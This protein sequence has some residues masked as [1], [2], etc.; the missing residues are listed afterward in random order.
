MT[1]T[2]LDTQ[3]LETA[4]G[5]LRNRISVIPINPDTKRPYGR[6]LPDELDERGQ[7]VINPQTKRPK[8]TWKPYQE[9]YA[10]EDE[11]RT[12]HA[13]GAQFAAV[14]GEISGGL[15]CIDHDDVGGRLLFEEWRA[16]VDDLADGLTTQQTGGGGYQVAYRYPVPPATTRDGNQKLAWLADDTQDTGR[17]VAIETRGEGGYFVIAPSLHPSG[18][19]YELLCGSWD[20]I[21]TISA[22]HR[23]SLLDAARRLDEMPHTRQELERAREQAAKPKATT[24]IANVNGDASVIVAYNAKTAIA[25]ELRQHGYQ[26]A[27]HGRLIRP[28]AA[29]DSQPGVVLGSGEH[30]NMSFHHSSND[31]LN[32]GYWHAPFDVRC[33]YDFNSDVKAAV[34]ALAAE[35]GMDHLSNIP[36]PPRDTEGWAICPNCGNRL[37][38]AKN[39]NGW[40]C[41]KDGGELC[42]WWKGE[43][44]TAPETTTPV[45]AD[46]GRLTIDISTIDL[47]TIMPQ[48]WHAIIASN[49]PPTLFRRAGEL[50]RLETTESGAMVV[51]TIDTRVMTGILARAARWIRV[52]YDR[53]GNA[54]EKETLPPPAI[55]DDCMVNIDPRIPRITRV[56]HATRGN[57]MR[58]VIASIRSAVQRRRSRR[59]RQTWLLRASATA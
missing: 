2:A 59:Q 5:A 22:A 48:A 50:A 17:S 11:V 58:N 35:L 40:R 20:N 15:E 12:W 52:S 3:L 51:K 18:N 49:D 44:Y 1:Q 37:K 27:A 7:V 32:D 4:L 31:P 39:G 14:G 16:A 8:K 38:P 45:V 53:K 47:P 25:D 43:G 13:A 28:N 54:T 29:A 33:S 30:D 23:A 46:D 55:V 21:P 56:V 34:K 19:R 24:Y 26:D 9:R 42:Y 57:S 36:E 41:L 6:L 10:T